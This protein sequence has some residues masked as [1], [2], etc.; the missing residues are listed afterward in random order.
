MALSI[1]DIING[2][3][4]VANDIGRVASDAINAVLD[5]DLV[6]IINF[7]I[8]YIFAPIAAL[9]FIWVFFLFIRYVIRYFIFLL[10]HWMKFPKWI[11]KKLS[12]N[13][14]KHQ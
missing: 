13:F 2:I 5:A 7:F 3:G 11:W 8:E 10:N 12:H 4:S 1:R 6:G 14:Y 9:F